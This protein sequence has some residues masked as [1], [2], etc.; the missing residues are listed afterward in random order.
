[1]KCFSAIFLLFFFCLTLRGQLPQELPASGG[2][3]KPVQANMDIRHYTLSLE[4]DIEKKSINGYVEITM[5]LANSSDSILLDLISGYQIR[6]L[7]V[8]KKPVSFSHTH[9]QI[10]ITSESTFPKGRRIVRIHYSGQPPIAKNPPWDGGFTWTT[11]KSGSPWVV[12]NCQM[13]GGKIYFPCKDHPGDE[14]DDGVD[15]FVIVPANLKVAGPGLLQSVKTSKDKSTW[16]WKTG[17]PISNYCILFNIGNYSVEK[18]EYV[19]IAN[20]KVP[21]EF[22]VT[23]E[24]RNKAAAL[25]EMRKRD[26]RILEKYFGEYPWIKE[27]IGIAEVPNYGME[28]QTMITYGGENFEF[29]QYNDFKYSPNLFHEFTHEWFANKI[30]NKDWSHFWIQEGITT[31]AEALFFREMQG[32]AAYDSVMISQRAGIQNKRPLVPGEDLTTKEVYSGDIY[33][34]GSYLIHTLRY[35]M[36]DSLFFPALKTLSTN[37]QPPY[38]TF[39][40]SEDVEKHFSALAGTS[41]KPVFDFY[42][43]TTRTLDVHVVRVEPDR[44]AIA[45]ENFPTELPVEITTDA[46]TRK[47][48]LKNPENPGADQMLIIRS[49][50]VPVV[51][52]RNWYF[53]KVIYQ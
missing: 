31:Y 9:N 4:V 10:A 22:Y 27:K 49:R 39:L 20:H 7:L 29:K 24:H 1:M 13:E 30:T 32:E 19:T 12:V 11:D 36:G 23:N 51:D 3:L 41:L 26:T 8:D 42:L 44:Y 43:R 14:P 17:Y 47:Y 46:G 50:T 18:G 40:T 45:V 25:I 28:H 16:H 21:I 52:P 38:N 37:I 53:K 2:K 48:M 5:E 15:L 34:K 35:L 33:N 6:S